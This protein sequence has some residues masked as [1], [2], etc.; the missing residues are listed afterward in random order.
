MCVRVD[1]C[2]VIT[3]HEECGTAI[4]AWLVDLVSLAVQLHFISPRGKE[5]SNNNQKQ[6]H[7]QLHVLLMIFTRFAGKTKKTKKQ[8]KT[9]K[10]G[11]WSKANT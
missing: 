2:C 7:C 11:D 6:G 1:C 9:K 8:N 4:K 5:K 10:H 3:T